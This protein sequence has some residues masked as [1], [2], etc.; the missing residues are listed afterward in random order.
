M[1]TAGSPQ[2]ATGVLGSPSHGLSSFL[3]LTQTSEHLHVSKGCRDWW[4]QA[5]WQQ[6]WAARPW[7]PSMRMGCLSP[8]TPVPPANVLEEMELGE[9]SSIKTLESCAVLNYSWW[10]RRSNTR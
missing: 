8:T 5:P 3:M 6:L 10:M 1:P 4:K 7:P 9:K 2:Q